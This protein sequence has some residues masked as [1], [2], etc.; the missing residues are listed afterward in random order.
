MRY[1]AYLM[2]SRY[3]CYSDDDFSTSSRKPS[4][5]LTSYPHPKLS[6]LSFGP[7]DLVSLKLLDFMSL[8]AELMSYSAFVSKGQSMV[9]I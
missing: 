3:S 8:R 7:L 5:T 9:G 2:Y 1:I 6:V 4:L